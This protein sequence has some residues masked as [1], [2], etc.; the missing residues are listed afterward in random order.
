MTPEALF[1]VAS[2]AVVPGWLLLAVS[3]T[4]RWTRRYTTV[5]VPVLLGALYVYLM[6]THF[7]DSGGGFGSLEDVARLFENE[8]LLL[9]GWIHYLVFDLFVGAWEA[10]DARRAGLRHVLI[11]PCLILTFMLGP[12]GLLAYLGLRTGVRGTSLAWRGPPPT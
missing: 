10:R 12:V 8:H 4:W 1:V 11:I 2:A 9:A 7:G 6:A 3:P 5:V